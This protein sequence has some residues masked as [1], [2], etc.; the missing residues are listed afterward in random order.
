M[1]APR[2]RCT[3]RAPSSSTASSCAAL[4][5]SPNGRRVFVVGESEGDYISLAYRMSDGERVW[6]KR[7]AAGARA[8]SVDVD[9]NGTAVFVTGYDVTV[10]YDRAS[11]AKLWDRAVGANEL[12]V[13]SDGDAV[14]VGGGTLTAGGITAYEA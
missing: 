8:L 13:A 3:T 11:G 1:P 6:R 14:F 12:A 7:F 5:A 2:G 4:A 10:A 9:P